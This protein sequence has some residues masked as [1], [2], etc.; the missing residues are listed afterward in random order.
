[1]S[2]KC[3]IWCRVQRSTLTQ[4]ISHTVHEVRFSTYSSKL[5]NSR[6]GGCPSRFLRPWG[7]RWINHWSLWLTASVSAT[8]EVSTVWSVYDWR[9][10]HSTASRSELY[11]RWRRWRI[12]HCMVPHHLTWRRH[13]H[14]SPTCRTDAGSGPPPVNSLTFRPV[15]GQLSEVVPFL[16]LE[17]RYGM[18]CQAMLLRPR[19][20]RCSR[21]GWR[22]TCSA[23]ATKLFNFNDISFPSHY[24]PSRTV[25]L[26]IVFTV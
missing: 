16:L 17:Q 15:V 23:A 2:L 9:Q 3:S 24:L 13:S 4:S 18:A 8:I 7:R 11:S 20:C 5:L 21:T 25:V 10:N 22:H 6:V 1:M 12:V 14:V 19:R 26:A